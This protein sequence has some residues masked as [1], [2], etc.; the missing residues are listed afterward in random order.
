MILCDP[1]ARSTTTYHHSP[2][3]VDPKALVSRGN[4]IS[5]GLVPRGDLD[6][7][8]LGSRSRWIDLGTKQFDGVETHGYR[9]WVTDQAGHVEEANYTEQ[10]VAETEGVEYLIS[11]VE[12]SHEE[13]T[14]L[15]DVRKLEP[16]P[17]LFAIPPGYQIIDDY[18]GGPIG[19]GTLR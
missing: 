9:W 10:W 6:R 2:A 8:R 11:N 16:D 19:P 5:P 14:E 1:L 18:K 17:V 4:G 12:G 7:N 15:V 13:R 3:L